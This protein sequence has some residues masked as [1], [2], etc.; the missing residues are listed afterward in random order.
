MPPER[1][2][3]VEISPHGPTHEVPVLPSPETGIQCVQQCPGF[4]VH[5]HPGQTVCFR[6]TV[7]VDLGF[8]ASPLL[9]LGPLCSN[10]ARPLLFGAG[11]RLA[12]K[13]TLLR[14][15]LLCFNGSIIFC[16]SVIT[17]PVHADVSKYGH[18][19]EAS[20]NDRSNRDRQAMLAQAF[21]KKVERG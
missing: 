1:E 14:R 8:G 10:Y 5:P 16:Q 6:D 17:L 11:S 4:T 19:D 9:L 12:G 3:F 2:R 13:I 20:Q 7:A 21:A 18:A 15:F